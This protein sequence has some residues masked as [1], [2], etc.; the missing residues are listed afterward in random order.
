M[1]YDRYYDDKTYAERHWWLEWLSDHVG[2]DYFSSVTR[3]GSAPRS[4]SDAE[5]FHIGQLTRIELLYFAGSRATDAGLENLERLVKLRHSDLDTPDVTDAGVVRLRGL[6]ALEVR[7][8]R[9]TGHRPWD[10]APEGA[11]PSPKLFC[12]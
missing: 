1:V 5:L 4:A 9:R 10:N 8:P 6:T 12:L 3:V 7:D 11:D 2:P